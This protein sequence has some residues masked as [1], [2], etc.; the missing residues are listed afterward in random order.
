MQSRVHRASLFGR[1]R[2]KQETRCVGEVT[3]EFRNF[4]VSAVEANSPLLGSIRLDTD[5]N[6]ILATSQTLCPTQNTY[7]QSIMK[8]PQTKAVY[9]APGSRSLPGKWVKH[10]GKGE[11]W[12]SVSDSV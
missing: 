8:L 2:V 4:T 9:Q 1:R 6:E 10:F 7:W 12:S 5:L 11:L 3:L